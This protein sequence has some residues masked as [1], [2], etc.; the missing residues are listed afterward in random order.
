MA[1]TPI[2]HAHTLLFNVIIS[3]QVGHDPS[4]F[5]T[6]RGESTPFRLSSNF[7]LLSLS[8]QPPESIDASVAF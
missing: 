6:D 1:M 2:V 5:S 7:P 8:D 3:G 4:A